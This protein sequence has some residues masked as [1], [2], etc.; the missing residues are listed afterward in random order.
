[1]LNRSSDPNTQQ[2]GFTLIEL[3]IVVT[4]VGVLVTLAYPAYTD[5]INQG[6]RTD[7]KAFILEVAQRQERYLAENDT[8][9]YNLETL[10][11]DSNLSEEGFYLVNIMTNAGAVFIT[12]L[13]SC[14][15]TECILIHA[16]AQGAQADDGDLAMDHEGNKYRDR[17]GDGD[18]LD[19]D[20]TGW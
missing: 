12:P 18:F 1:M 13:T 2:D 3:M 4:I 9:S 10:G 17:N 14:E 7:G 8:Y 16:S 19:D 6:R 11:Y 5:F 15:V 20:E